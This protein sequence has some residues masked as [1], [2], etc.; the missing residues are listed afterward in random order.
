MSA[1]LFMFV[2]DLLSIPFTWKNYWSTSPISAFISSSKCLAH[3]RGFAY[4]AVWGCSRQKQEQIMRKTQIYTVSVTTALFTSASS[5][6]EIFSYASFSPAVC[7]VKAVLGLFSSFFA[8]VYFPSPILYRTFKVL[9]A[10]KFKHTWLYTSASGKPAVC[11]RS[12]RTRCEMTAPRTSL[13][14]ISTENERQLYSGF[15]EISTEVR[16]SGWKNY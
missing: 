9:W 15:L 2:S 4:Y 5:N 1:F 7:V 8:V 16:L 10:A 12:D 6:G 14:V 11:V 13:K 3:N